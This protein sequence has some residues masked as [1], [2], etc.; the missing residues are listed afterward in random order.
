MPERRP[1]TSVPITDRLQRRWYAVRRAVLL[2][3]RLLAA[4]CLGLA[5][6]V[7][8]RAVAPLPPETVTVSV[9]AHDLSAGSVL[10]TEDLTDRE[11]DPAHVPA[12]LL[13]AG[14]LHGRTLTAPVRAG[15][16]LTDARTLAPDLLA[17]YPGAVAVPVRIADAGSVGLLRV[18]DRIDV[19]AADP[20]GRATGGAV[21]VARGAT[22]VALPTDPASAPAAGLGGRL[23]V[24][25]TS[26]ATAEDLAWAGVNRHLSFVLGG[27]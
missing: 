6:F 24:L 26:A 10:T 4:L 25:A 2:R 14:D 1:R 23:V 7:G 19:T 5:A 3:R 17:G 13:A 9:A 18:G 16:M 15:E 22:V 11:V 12:G 27:S 21:T 8:L 20:H